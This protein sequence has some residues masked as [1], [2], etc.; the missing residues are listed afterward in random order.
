M[1]FTF[2][3]AVATAALMIAAPSIAQMPS[4]PMS[5]GTMSATDV[6]VSPLTGTSG[7]DYVKLAADS[8][9]FEIQSGRIA[10]MKSK[11]TDVR[12]FAKQMISAHTGTTKSLMAALNNQDRKI[13][14]PSPKL[15]AVNQAKID[16]LRKAPK[17]SFDQIY[18]KQQFEAHQNA[19]ALHKGY[20]TD[21]TDASLKQVAS[22]AVPI[23]E[24]HLAMLKSMPAGM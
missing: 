14:P 17:N 7:T 23:V 10:E 6:G 12:A 11:R 2:R 8:D 13:T 19:W 3:T 24:S 9:N 22:T 5:S 20:E 16:L 1:K 15:S 21:G 18:L 4:T